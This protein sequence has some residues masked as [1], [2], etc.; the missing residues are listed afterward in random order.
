MHVTGY[1]C[2]RPP[3][4][5]RWRRS[6][7]RRSYSISSAWSARWRGMKT[8]GRRPGA[9]FSASTRCG[10]PAGRRR[11]PWLRHQLLPPQ[12]A[13]PRPP[14][15]RSRRRQR[16][17]SRWAR[18]AARRARRAARW[19]RRRRALQGQPG[20]AHHCGRHLRCPVGPGGQVAEEAGPGAEQ[21]DASRGQPRLRRGPAQRRAGEGL[22]GRLDAVEVLLAAG[23]DPNETDTLGRTALM[24]AASNGESLLSRQPPTSH[25]PSSTTAKLW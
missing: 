24:L 8:V 14:R 21:G 22:E 3:W 23:S 7:S 25:D 10:R 20:H 15:A 4:S 6:C 17:R 2:R 18:R 1:S 11:P 5:R 9:F 12:A 16:R 19:A 13:A